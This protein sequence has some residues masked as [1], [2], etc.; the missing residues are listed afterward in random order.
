M[1]NCDQKLSAV[2]NEDIGKLILRLSIAILMLFHG[3]KKYVSGINGIKGLTVNAGLPEVFAYGVYVGEILIPILLII[4]FRTRICALLL[5]LTM[6]F[7]I[8]LV[9][10]EKLFTIDAKTGGLLIELP[11]LYLLS[12]LAL[13]FIGGGK[14]GVDYKLGSCQCKCEK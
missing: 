2:L 8:F 12:S 1:F 9:F 3:Y 4:G 6:G 7:A 10:S 11:L 14:Y 13:F 5:S